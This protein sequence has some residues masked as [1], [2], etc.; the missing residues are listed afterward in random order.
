MVAKAPT[1]S[2]Q[3][4]LQRRGSIEHTVQ[5]NE[6]LTEIASLYGVT[7]A[8]VVRWN[9]LQQA[10]LQAGSTLTIYLEPERPIGKELSFKGP[11]EGQ[12]GASMPDLRNLTYKIVHT[13]VPGDTLLELSKRYKVSTDNL[14]L[15]N[16]LEDAAIQE[17]QKLTIF[18]ASGSEPA[19]STPEL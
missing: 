7:A 9:H 4:T 2:G 15:W 10:K 19:K 18:V 6:L 3:D 16:G 17:G 1:D 8:D 13:V 11:G 5:E 14:T 12:K